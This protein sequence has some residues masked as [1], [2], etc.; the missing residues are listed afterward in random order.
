MA[1]FRRSPRSTPPLRRRQE[2]IARQEAELREKLE[3]LERMVTKAPVIAQNRS[4]AQGAEQ[5]TRGNKTGKRLHVSVA[6]KGR[7]SLDES[8]RARRPRSLRKER[9]EGRI[10]FLFLATA[11]AAAVIWLISHLHS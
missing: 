3:K 5:G 6:L 11:L 9:R 8:R 7:R 2:E 1:M 10:I 4:P